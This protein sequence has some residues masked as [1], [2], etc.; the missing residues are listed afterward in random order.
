MNSGGAGGGEK[1]GVVVP[2]GDDMDMEMKG[3]AGSCGGTEIDAEI[4]SIRL[5]G[6]F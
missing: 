6:L 1:I 3:D 5:H 2:A 4:K